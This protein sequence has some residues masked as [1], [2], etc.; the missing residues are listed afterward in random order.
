MKESLEIVVFSGGCFV[1][2]VMVGIVFLTEA[3]VSIK[4]VD[5]ACLKDWFSIWFET[6]S[7]TVCNKVRNQNL[8]V[9]WQIRS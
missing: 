3:I 7:S 1:T 2:P 9:P 4:A 6:D 5:L 8:D